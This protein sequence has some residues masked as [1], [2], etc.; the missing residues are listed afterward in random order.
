MQVSFP[1]Q[2]A[3]CCFFDSFLY[4]AKASSFETVHLYG[5]FLGHTQ[6]RRKVTGQG[7]NPRHS[8]DPSHNNDNPGSLTCW[9]TRELPICLFVLLFCF[10]HPN[11]CCPILGYFILFYFCLFLGP[12]PV[13]KLLAYTRATA[14][15]DPS[16]VCDLHHSSRQ[17]WILN[18]L[19][20][21]MDQ[22]HNLT[23][24]SQIR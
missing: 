13:V 1:I 5:G 12:L 14:M 3:A 23:V 2:L 8:S 9:D 4:Y 11:L 16:S 10:C 7:F 22:T 24:P 19:S 20:K 17:C 15:Q 18:P 6:G 21:A